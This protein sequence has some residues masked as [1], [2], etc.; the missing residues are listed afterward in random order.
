MVALS[1][2]AH[3]GAPAAVCIETT[4]PNQGQNLW[5]V[6]DAPRD[7]DDLVE[8]LHAQGCERKRAEDQAASQVPGHP[9]LYQP[10]PQ[11][12]PG[13]EELRWPPGAAQIPAQRRHRG[14]RHQEVPAGLH[15]PQQKKKKKKQ[16]GEE[17][18]KTE[19]VDEEK[20]L[21]EEA[22]VATAVE[23][24][25]TA[26]REAQTFSRMHVLLGMLDACIKWDMSAENARCKVCRKK[27]VSDPQCP[28][29][30]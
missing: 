4:T 12:E 20:K 30:V 17:S 18:R 8:S 15:G 23:K 10:G 21:A 9:P 29:A 1:E 13:A 26:I 7:L 24:W 11:G 27:G 14:L 25:K 22:R 3:Q 19:E 16:E 6:C 5:F 28:G 2:G